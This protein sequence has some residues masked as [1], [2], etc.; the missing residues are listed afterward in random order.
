MS[1]Q[2]ITSDMTS[3]YYARSAGEVH[4]SLRV[5][6]SRTNSIHSVPSVEYIH[7]YISLL[8]KSNIPHCRP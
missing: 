3:E 6:I 7:K 4:L 2:Y 5:Q 8:Y 1:R